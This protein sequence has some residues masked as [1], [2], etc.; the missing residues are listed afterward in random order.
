MHLKGGLQ[1]TQISNHTTK[2]LL[3]EYKRHAKHGGQ[4]LVVM[5]DETFAL[6]GDVA[7][8]AGVTPCI[9][10]NAIEQYEALKPQRIL[11]TSLKDNGLNTYSQL[12]WAKDLGIPVVFCLPSRLIRR[13]APNW[14]HSGVTFDGMYYLVDKYAATLRMAH[15]NKEKGSYCEFGVF[16]GR[17]F[18]IAYHALKNT[19]N[20]FYAFD[21]FAGIGDTLN[22]ETTHF[23][24]SGFYANQASFWYNMQDAGADVSRIT[25][26]PGFFNTSLLNK[27]PKDFGI[28]DIYCAHIDVDV[29]VPALQALRFITPALVDEALI[30]FDDY[31]QM[32]ADNNRGERRAL[33]EWL[34]ETGYTAELY[35]AYATFG[36]TFIIHKSQ[37]LSS[38][39]SWRSMLGMK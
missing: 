31:D 27:T 32:A 4:T 23:V 13:A 36:R 15:A 16:D 38:K 35:R 11:V 2:I 7:I 12:K 20:H 25:A 8:Q 30:M 14:E 10:A 19:C 9:E 26:I 39:K 24:D 28:N 33:R 5:D 17:T 1:M 37:P 29:Y 3:E 6:Y 21:S 18:S 34:A 22:E